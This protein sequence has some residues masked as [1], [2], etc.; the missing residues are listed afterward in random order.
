MFSVSRVL[1]AAVFVAAAGMLSD[2]AAATVQVRV[3]GTISNS[4]DMTGLF[5]APGSTLDGQAFTLSY[6]F[7]TTKGYRDNQG[8]S[9]YDVV[10]GGAWYGV[11]SPT[12]SATLSIG[13]HTQSIAGQ[14]GS[15]YYVCDA[16]YC[17]GNSFSASAADYQPVGPNL[18]VYNSVGMYFTDPSA[19]VP[20]TLDRSFTYTPSRSA[21]VW[22]DFQFQTF[23]TS[24]WTYQTLTQGNLSIDSVTVAAVPLP[25]AGLALLGALGGLGAMSRRRRETA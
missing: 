19:N 8:P 17:G 12:L 9:Y 22:G 5:G 3:N 18:S 20:D 6:K 7:D 13:G 2:A 4:S 14:G 23:D 1:T 11:Q 15:T 10:Y 25:A 16:S 24:T 21:T